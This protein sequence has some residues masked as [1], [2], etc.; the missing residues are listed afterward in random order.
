[1][2]NQIL[3]N[4]IERNL[5]GR[6]LLNFGRQIPGMKFIQS[7]AHDFIRTIYIYSRP[8]IEIAHCGWRHGSAINNCYVQAD[9]VPC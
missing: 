9:S 3:R 2:E 5:L 8:H 4:K 1:M 6:H 7:V